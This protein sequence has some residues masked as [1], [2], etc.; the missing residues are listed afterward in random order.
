VRRGQRAGGD[1]RVVWLLL[2]EDGQNLV[3]E[4]MRLRREEI[5]RLVAGAEIHDP[6]AVAA[7]L[8]NLVT[9]AGETP[10]PQWW[11]LWASSAQFDP[12]Q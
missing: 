3:G 8:I 1:R 4:V 7:G 6:A 5:A 9:A 2:T 11:D 10:D 12:D